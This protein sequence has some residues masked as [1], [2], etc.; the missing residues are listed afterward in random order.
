MS[1]YGWI[2]TTRATS[3]TV[4]DS[5][6]PRS[7]LKSTPA[8]ARSGTTSSS[9]PRPSREQL[10]DVAVR[11]QQ[12]VA[13]DEPGAAVGQRRV[14]G[15]LDPADRRD[16]RLDGRPSGPRSPRCSNGARRRRVLPFTTST[17]GR[18]FGRTIASRASA[19]SSG[20][21]LVAF[22]RAT[23]SRACSFSC[24]VAQGPRSIP[25]A[26]S[27]SGHQT[28]DPPW[29]SDPLGEPLDLLWLRLPF[30]PSLLP[31]SRFGSEE[32]RR[33]RT[34]SWRRPSG[35]LASTSP[36]CD[37]VTGGGA[38]GGRRGPRASPAAGATS[39]GRRRSSTPRTCPRRRPRHRTRA[40]VPEDVRERSLRLVQ[41]SS[42]REGA[43][44]SC[45]RS[46]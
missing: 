41:G 26:N 11:H 3:R 34:P 39:A 6:R 40:D 23:A 13:D 35:R 10:G 12:A 42:G 45:A 28:P 31:P 14:V 17:T 7:R 8:R 16:R 9:R 43:A 4:C 44:T 32:E 1:Q 33:R 5:A 36:P 46:L 38:P 20:E 18:S 15:Q 29:G 21:R 24:A 19:C 2:I 37:A 25:R 30:A 22:S 27:D